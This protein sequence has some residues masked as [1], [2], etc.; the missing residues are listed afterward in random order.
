MPSDGNQELHELLKQHRDYIRNFARKMLIKYGRLDLLDD[1]VQDVH[2]RI[3]RAYKPGLHGFKTW[4]CEITR[5]LIIDRLRSRQCRTA[6]GASEDEATDSAHGFLGADAP[7]PVELVMR[8]ELCGLVL[9]ALETLSPEHRR[10]VKMRHV[11]GLPFKL[12][13]ERLGVPENTARLR[14]WRAIKDL[15]AHINAGQRTP[16][17]HRRFSFLDA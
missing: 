7:T 13:A 17:P 15:R 8:K 6:C 2:E 10:I 14:L 16:R 4:V 5:N 3:C 1:L 12:I 9:K 11:D